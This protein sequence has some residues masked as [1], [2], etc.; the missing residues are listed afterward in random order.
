VKRSSTSDAGFIMNMAGGR[1]IGSL[2]RISMP[3]AGVDAAS[4]PEAHNISIAHDGRA[5]ET[6]G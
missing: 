4:G 1:M 5:A 2:S 3:A 6:C